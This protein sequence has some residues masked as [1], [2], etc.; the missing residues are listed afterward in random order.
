MLSLLRVSMVDSLALYV[1]AASGLTERE[2]M[3]MTH[4]VIAQGEHGR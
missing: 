2:V 3:L 4:V 1:A